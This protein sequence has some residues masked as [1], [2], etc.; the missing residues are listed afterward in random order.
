MET[1]KLAES[2]SSPILGV[3]KEEKLPSPWLPIYLYSISIIGFLVVLVAFFFFINNWTGLLI[4]AGVASVAHLLGDVELFNNSRSRVLFHL[5]LQSP[6]LYYLGQ[7][8]VQLSRCLVG[9]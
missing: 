7:W 6:V 4:F 3:S 1:S 9:L 2:K 8:Q 5:L